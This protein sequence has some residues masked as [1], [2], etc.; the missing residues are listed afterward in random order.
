MK[1]NNFRGD[2]TDV[3]AKKEALLYLFCWCLVIA[4]NHPHAWTAD[5]GNLE[6]YKL[7]ILFQYTKTN[8]LGQWYRP[9]SENFLWLN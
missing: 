5:E 6:I 2:V 3:S 7:Y 4:V 1:I 9:R 8:R